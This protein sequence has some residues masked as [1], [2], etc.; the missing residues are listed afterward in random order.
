MRSHNDI[1]YIRK[2]VEAL[3]AQDVDDTVEIIS[4]DDRSSDGTSEYLAGVPQ[5]HRVDP[6]EGRYVPGR[7]LN[8]MIRCARGEYIVFN[9]ADAVPKNNG[10][11]KKLIG[12]LKDPAVDCVFG[13]QVARAD[14]LA[15]VRKDYERAFGDGSISR[16][17]PKFFSLVTSGFRKEDLLLHPFDETFQYSED[18]QW[19]NR[20]D[21][22]IVYVPEAMVEHSHNYTLPEVQK[23]FFNEGAAD[24]QM[25]KKSPGILCTWKRILAETLRDWIYLVKNGDLHEFWYA[26][27]YRYVQKMSY[28]RGTKQ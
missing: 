8:H 15:V 12:P 2:T 22:K 13:N 18:A 11:L 1:L 23:R 16:H 26:P 6:P 5:I 25:G 17:W 9:N 27:C 7:T 24:K 21:V 19:V 10:Y 4:C 28:Y 3:L 14:A 20:R